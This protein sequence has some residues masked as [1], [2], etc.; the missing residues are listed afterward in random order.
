MLELRYLIEDTEDNMPFNI[1][2]FRKS[3]STIAKPSHF[4]INFIGLP[5]AVFGADAVKRN[6][7]IIYRAYN[8]QL[9]GINL[10]TIERRY[11]GPLR[12]I[13]V[14]FMYQQLSVA[15][16]ENSDYDVRDLFDTWTK[17]LVLKSNGYFSRYYDEIVAQSVELSLFDTSGDLIRKY[18]FNE[19]YPI[20]ISPV[21]LD[22]GYRDTFISIN[23]EFAYRSWD[24]LE[25]T[26]NNPVVNTQ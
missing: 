10:D 13:P 17:N 25:I 24:V 1:K 11:H 2:T 26:K 9:P 7:G 18:R 15:F 3:L 22:W 8:A 16:I 4:E 19:V 5:T 21:G 20:G 14:N 23:V 6:S 12:Q